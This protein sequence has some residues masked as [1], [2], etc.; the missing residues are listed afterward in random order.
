MTDAKED[1]PILTKAKLVHIIKESEGAKEVELLESNIQALSSLGKNYS[2]DIIFCKLKAKVDG[3]NK[4]FDWAIKLPPIAAKE[5]MP[6][7]RECNVE[8]K[9]IIFYRE[10]LPA[11]EKLVEEKKA[12]FRFSSWPSPYAEFNED[13]SKGSILVMKNLKTLGFRDAIDIKRGLDIYHAKLALE[14]L[15]KFHALGHAY[16]NNYPGG[17]KEGLKKNEIL[18]TDY[19]FVN[20][21]ELVKSAVDTVNETLFSGF[22][23][24]L[25]VVQEPGQ[26]FVGALNR[27]HEK[28]NVFSFR[29]ELYTAKEG[30]FNAICHGDTHLNNIMFRYEEKDGQLRPVQASWVDISITRYANP[31]G[32]LSYFLYTSTTPQLRRTHLNHLL[33]HYHSTLARCLGQLGKDPASY[34]FRY[35]I[36]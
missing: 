7:H 22:A 26:D 33:E 16:L 19:S 29:K 4:D 1:H 20:Q 30:E 34:P 9:E 27:M 35:A 23:H 5:R 3:K 21:S 17:V 2:G 28:K 12:N 24:L 13:I 11:L 36:I 18:T 14:E 8:K 32:D 6:M 10:L 31:C 25:D 15:A